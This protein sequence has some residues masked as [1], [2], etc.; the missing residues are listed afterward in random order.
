[1]IENN[2]EHTGR[3]NREKPEILFASLQTLLDSFPD[4][5]F[6]KDM[7]F[8]Y[9]AGTKS[10]AAMLGQPSMAEVLGR[11]DYD[12]LGEELGAWFEP[13]ASGKYSLVIAIRQG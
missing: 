10:F 8:V 4:M 7:N 12:L 1:M 3:M 11:T 9:V 5:I 2:I 13:A 6:V